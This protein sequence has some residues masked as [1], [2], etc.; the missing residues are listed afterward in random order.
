MEW[1]HQWWKEVLGEEPAPVSNCPPQTSRELGRDRTQASAMTGH[2]TQNSSLKSIFLSIVPLLPK[3]SLFSA[4]CQPSN[5]CPSSKSKLQTY[6]AFMEW[7]SQEKTEVLGQK[8]CPS[9]TL[10]ITNLIGWTK[11]Q[12]DRFSLG[13]R[14]LHPTVSGHLPRI[15]IGSYGKHGFKKRRAIATEFARVT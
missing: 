6:V 3:K 2:G 7:H 10:S 11:W 1:H 12:W 14:L 9:A 5:I 4:V 13:F 8:P 15:L